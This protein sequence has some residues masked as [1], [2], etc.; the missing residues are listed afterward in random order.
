[1]LDFLFQKGAIKGAQKVVDKLEPKVNIHLPEELPMPSVK[2]V[3][4][5]VGTVALINGFEKKLEVLSDEQLQ[6]KTDEFRA[7]YPQAVKKELDEFNKL[8]DLRLKATAVEEKDDLSIKIEKAQEDFR[9]VK[10]QFLKDILPEAFAVV[11]EAGKRILSMRHYDV[12]M[13][14]G[15]VLNGGN[16]TE[17][18]TGEGKTLVAT[19]PAYLNALTGEGVH[20][21]TVNDYLA[22]RDKEWMGP[23]FEFLGLTVG[24]ILHDMIPSERKIAY[25]CDITYGTNNEFGF[26]YL[27]DNMVNFKEDM[28]Q[29][30]HHFS[31]VDEVDS[32]LVDEARTPL[33]ISGPAD[34]A[35]DKYYK[36]NEAAKKL[37]GRRI[38]EKDEV[39]AKH[40]EVD[41]SEGYD[42][43]ADEKAKSVS[44]TETGEEAA[45]KLLGV[46]NLHEMETIEFRHHILQALKAH[47][48][49]VPDVDYVLQDGEVIIVDEFT[50]RMMPGR[51]WSDG[52][53]QA[54]EAKE[55]IKI[56]R[57][58]QT[59]ATI[60]FQNYFRLYEKLSGMT[61]TANTE[62]TEF[63]QIYD[64]DCVVMPTNKKLQRANYPD[65]IYKTVKEKFVAVVEEIEE[66]HKKGQPVLV[67]TIS[68]EKSELLG[69]MLKQKGVPH[70]VLN[71]KFHEQEAHIISQAGRYGAVTI[72]TNMAGRGTDIVLGGN[73]E[74]LAETLAS[75]KVKKGAS[76]EELEATTKK[77]IEQFKQQCS[78]EHKKVLEIGGLH[79]LGTERHESRRIDN[80]LRGRQGRQGDPGSS[81]FFVSLEDDLMRLFA[82]DKII[83]LMDK[84]GMEEGQS[85]EHPWLSKSIETAQRRVEGHNFEI[86]KHLLEYDNV[87]NRQREVIYDLRREVLEREEIK[88]MIMGA[89][90]DVVGEEAAH[91]LYTP[92]EGADSE[93]DGFDIDGLSAYLKMHFNYNFQESKEKLQEMSQDEVTD[94]VVKGVVALYEAREQDIDVQA[95]RH[96]ERMVMLNTIDA[97]WKDHLYAMDQLK[98]GVGLRSFAQRDPLIEYKKE[99]FLM[100]EQMYG[101]INREVVE[102][103]FKMQPVEPSHHLKGVFSSLPQ[104]LIHDEMSGMA[105]AAAQKP[106]PPSST[107]FVSPERSKAAPVH[108][109]NPKVG[110]NDPCPCGSG[111]KHKKCCGG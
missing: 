21:V 109:A 16:I 9:K 23:L 41:L 111:K 83:G 60:T 20:V 50:G 19:L 22:N 40:A 1:M 14:G 70:N 71:A 59:L 7:K 45:A 8:K 78:E 97:K 48:F 82:S 79:V 110:R 98:E 104:N 58:N 86:R 47:E 2:V 73:V 5:M 57:E 108:N 28:V 54:V 90:E 75:Q 56:E 15:M 62:A 95:L 43:M 39:D 92:K 53:H 68:I 3:K 87:M 63:K 94:L 61:G 42:Y 93:E 102:L 30:P 65:A 64:L 31:I 46:D 99:G 6:A 17:M 105:S 27:R 107:E 67:G 85:L 106:A 33:I 38:T 35:T 74:F 36:A 101:T 26:D 76:Q 37:K 88:S 25:E 96:M 4:Q 103:I 91:Y 52:L 29:R 77:F 72:A 44:L 51:R 100:F 81:R 18:T 13:L 69:R 89:I 34:E 80:Q 24:V 84:L 12:Q 49:F 55:G 32:I 66:C 10:Q 11:R